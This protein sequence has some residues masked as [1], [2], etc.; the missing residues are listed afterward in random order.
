M[1]ARQDTWDLLC[2]FESTSPQVFPNAFC[3]LCK[4]SASTWTPFPMSHATSCCH[5]STIF[6]HFMIW[7]YMQTW[8]G[9][10]GNDYELN[11]LNLRVFSPDQ[12]DPQRSP[13]H[14]ASTSLWRWPSR[15][16]GHQAEHRTCFMSLSWIVLMPHW[17]NQHLKIMCEK[18]SKN[19]TFTTLSDSMLSLGKGTESKPKCLT[20]TLTHC[21][22]T[23]INK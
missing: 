4:T 7:Y 16:Y 23:C 10:C 15:Q 20:M 1:L 18:L 17:C 11:Q 3:I 9:Y 14:V 21:V 12:R 5:T 22:Q 2:K 8:S 19:E 13:V 6:K